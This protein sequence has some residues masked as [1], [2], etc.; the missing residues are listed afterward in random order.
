MNRRL[1]LKGLGVGLLALNSISG[2]KG[3][4]EALGFGCEVKT[5]IRQILI[6]PRSM[7]MTWMVDKIFKQDPLIVT[8][9]DKNILWAGPSPYPDG[10]PPF[11]KLKS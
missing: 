4:V 11:V 2:L 7:G 1:F 3:A 8:L 6:K 9:T 10:L 5:T